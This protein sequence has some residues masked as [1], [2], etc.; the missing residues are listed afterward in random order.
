MANALVAERNRACIDACSECEQACEA[1]AYGCC[2]GSA[3]MVACGRLCLDCA[4]VST[5]CQTLLERG[6]A[7][8]TK[9]CEL[10]AEICEA[11]AAECAKHQDETCQRCAEAGRRCARECRAMVS[12]AS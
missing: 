7:W 3:E 2:M 9:V 6:S 11:C 10:C 4:A 5:L 12:V 1:C 8:A